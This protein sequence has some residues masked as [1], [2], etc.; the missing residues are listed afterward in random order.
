M[1]EINLF[2]AAAVHRDMTAGEILFNEGDLAEEMYG[3]IDGSFEIVRGDEVLETVEAGGVFGEVAL[4]G[5]N[6][7]TLCA[8]AKTDAVVAVVSED[9]FMKLVKMNA[10][11]ALEVMRLLAERLQRAGA[12]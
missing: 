12:S 1:P 2:R 10:F 6:H 4:L 5:D 3:V 8:R 7:R 11:F 9:E